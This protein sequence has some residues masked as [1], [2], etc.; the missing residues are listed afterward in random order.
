MG[1]SFGNR[2]GK[3]PGL[4]CGRYDFQI[5]RESPS[6]NWG[7][8]TFVGDSAGVYPGLFGISNG[9]KIIFNGPVLIDTSRYFQ[10]AAPFICRDNFSYNRAG[11]Q[12]LLTGENEFQGAVT[13]IA[14]LPNQRTRLASLD[15]SNHSELKKDNGGVCLDAADIDMVDV[16]GGAIWKAVNGSVVSGSFGWLLEPNRQCSG[17]VGEEIR[18]YVTRQPASQIATVQV[19]DQPQQSFHLYLVTLDGRQ[20]HIARSGPNKWQISFEGESRGIYILK[21]KDG[22]QTIGVQKYA[23]F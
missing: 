20:Q 4:R 2:R 5:V 8:V 21:L 12:V 9:S 18:M 19:T 1:V 17:Q 23:F 13:E 14:S 22:E 6:R 10:S 3:C 16:S 7:E 11:G 15:A